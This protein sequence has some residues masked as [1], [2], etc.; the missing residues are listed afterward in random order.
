MTKPITKKDENETMNRSVRNILDDFLRNSY[1]CPSGDETRMMAMD[2]IE[3]ENEYALL[4]NLPGIGKKNVKVS[5][6]G[7]DLIIEANRS[8]TKEEK[9]ETLYRCE[10]YHGNY[11]RV[12]T[13]PDDS[14]YEE[15]SADY[16]NGVLS[17]KVP[18]SKKQEKL[19]DIK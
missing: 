7:R 13:L 11:R 18:K 15:I 16:E 1:M 14:D 9:G 17:I 19:I 10:R 8:K 4:A 6:D 12:I 5:V 2:V 3:R